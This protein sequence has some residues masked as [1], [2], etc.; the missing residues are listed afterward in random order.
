MQYLF[1]ISNSNSYRCLHQIRQYL[2]LERNK[3][4]AHIGVAHRGE[5]KAKHDAFAAFDEE[6]YALHIGFVLAHAVELHKGAHQH[7]FEL[8]R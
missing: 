7:F 5:S 3:V 6:A 1:R 4:F 2:F 8:V